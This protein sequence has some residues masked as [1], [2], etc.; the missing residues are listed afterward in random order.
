MPEIE[1]DRTWRALFVPGATTSYGFDRIPRLPEPS[2]HYEPALAA[3][4][5][6]TARLAYQDDAAIRAAALAAAPHLDLREAALI[7]KQSMTC[8]VLVAG[9]AQRTIVAFRGTDDLRDW[10]TNLHG[11]TSSWKPGGRAHRGFKHAWYSLARELGDTL[12]V[13]PH[14]RLVCGHSLGG[15]LAT[16]EASRRGAETIYTLG[17]PRAG[18]AG[19][20][21]SVDAPH[22]RIVNYH[23]PVPEL[24]TAGPPFF[25]A[26]GGT[27]RHLDAA[28]AITTAGP[29]LGDRLR[30]LRELAASRAAWRDLAAN[31][32]Q[33]L[34][35][36]A[37]VNYSAK[38]LAA[39]HE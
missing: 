16:L 2:E 34:A 1:I 3:L 20:H 37:P 23:D 30:A 12:R 5:A 17:S 36:H 8:L 38:L 18:T 31:A 14:R 35:D 27:P 25:F 13:L 39:V 7:V 26:H 19:L 28:G 22:F 4:A 24:P 11:V 32:P 33:F 6:E 21:A 9:S 15:A 29:S 10:A